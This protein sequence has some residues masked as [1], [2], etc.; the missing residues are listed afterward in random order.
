MADKSINQV[1]RVIEVEH[2]VNE[3]LDEGWILLNVCSGSGASDNGPYQY[4]MYVL[5]WTSD[6]EAPSEI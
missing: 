1:K 6:E 4:P 2:G 5:G 3:Y